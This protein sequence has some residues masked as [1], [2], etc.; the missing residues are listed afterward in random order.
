[1]YSENRSRK[2]PHSSSSLAAAAAGGPLLLPIKVE[3]RRVDRFTVRLVLQL[4]HLIVVS[5]LSPST[6]ST[7]PKKTLFSAPQLGQGP[8]STSGLLKRTFSVTALDTLLMMG[9]PNSKANTGF[10]VTSSAA[11][12]SYT[13]AV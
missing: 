4:P 12:S 7:L 13:T 5:S 3:T 1:M 11:R 9:A 2:S 8:A 10:S 6:P